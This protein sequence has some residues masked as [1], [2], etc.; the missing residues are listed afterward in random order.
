MQDNSPPQSARLGI[1]IDFGTSNSAAAVF[2]GQQLT[3]V[4]LASPES[5]MPSANY[6]DKQYVSAIGQKAINDYISGNRGRKVEL[7]AELLGEARSGTGGGESA[8]GGAGE[9][10]TNKVYG[11]AFNDASLPGRLF[12]GTKRL[13]GN[14]LNDRIAIF[15]RSFRLVALVT[16]ILVGIRQALEAAIGKSA[17]HACIGHPVNFEGRGS[18]RNNIALE[19]LGESYGHA[20]ITQ[21]S[22]CPEPTAATISYLHNHPQSNDEL[23]LT[24]DF[25]GGT[26]DFSVLRRRGSNFEVEA[27]HGIALG[28]DR[29]DQ[30]IFRELVFPLLGRGERWSRVVDGSEVDTLFPFGEYED[31]LIN[32]PIS[33]MLNQNKY[34]APV[35]QRMAQPDEA[36]NKFKRLYDLIQQNY[37]YQI[38][39]AIKAFKAELSMR[40]AALLDIPEVDIQVEVELW[41]FEAMISPLLFEFEQAITR[42]LHKAGYQAGDIDLVLRTGGS[43]L[44]PAVKDIL[45]NQFAG[46]VVEHDPFTSVAAGL[47]IADYY[48]YAE[49]ELS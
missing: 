35:M 46:K 29:I 2:D 25:G 33:Y 16:P 42:I 43:S 36:A 40:N 31:L 11:Q 28:G 26:L 23:V 22:F 27:T 37:S 19:R 44:I 32:W 10:D 45:D 3:L 24:V 38:F 6:I 17:N 30:T 18:G 13:L 41:E 47:A 48:E 39:E 9:S 49:A 7:S 15:D 1:G 4:K 20:G 12:R 34:T 8:M 14:T 5:I 21:Q